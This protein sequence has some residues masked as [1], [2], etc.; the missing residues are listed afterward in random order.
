MGT[1]IVGDEK[2]ELSFLSTCRLTPDGLLCIIDCEENG[3]DYAFYIDINGERRKQYWYTEKNKILH[4]LLNEVV[5]TYQVTFFVRRNNGEITSKIISKRS[6]WALCDGVLEA[7]FQ[8]TTQ[9]S[10]ILEFG[11]GFGSK[12]IS[13]HRTITCVEH[14]EK[15]VGQFDGVNYIHAP[16][17]PIRPLGAFED[18]QWYDSEKIT[19]C[20]PDEIDMI[21]IDGPPQ[22]I[23]RSGILHNLDTFSRTPLWIIDDVH[24]EE[25]QRLANYI[26]FH[27]SMLHY[28]FWN[29][30]ILSH[31]SI[32][33]DL[34]EHILK[35]SNAV[36]FDEDK[37]YV[38]RFYPLTSEI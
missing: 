30:S 12:L 21:I 10:S 19:A 36:A 14:N 9:Q 2:L 26:S 38:A 3:V 22:N 35:A 1:T 4:P 7:V 32:P 16:L 27:F 23:G 13:D 37:K 25:D 24:R 20:L 8:L 28:R 17:V 6:R 5:N 18:T 15:F 33:A 34:I 31:K 29:F 11:S